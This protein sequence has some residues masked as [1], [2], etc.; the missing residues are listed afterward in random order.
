MCSCGEDARIAVIDTTVFEMVDVVGGVT[1]YRF[2][3]EPLRA[4]YPVVRGWDRDR[5]NQKF[6]R[7][8]AE[9][10]V[11]D[12]I[13]V[14]GGN[15]AVV[16]FITEHLSRMMTSLTLVDESVRGG[17]NI[18]FCVWS[19]LDRDELSALVDRIMFLMKTKAELLFEAATRTRQNGKVYHPG[20]TVE[21]SGAVFRKA[22]VYRFRL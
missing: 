4:R 7:M 2:G 1:T 3:E 15:R 6:A 19:R 9:A 11:L 10:F 20:Q 17:Q 22:G 12:G 16:E 8:L 5:Q 14:Q 18:E 21:V 13:Q